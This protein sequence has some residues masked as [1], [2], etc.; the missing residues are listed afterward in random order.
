MI[1]AYNYMLEA[2]PLKRN[3]KYPV[4]RRNELRRVYNN[5]VDLSKSSP[6]YKINLSRENQ[7]YT[8]GIKEAALALKAVIKDMKDPEYSGFHSKTV[9]VSNESVLSAALLNEDTANLPDQ[10][11]FHIKS[12]ASIQMNKGRDLLQNSKGVP[13][14]EYLFKAQVGEEEY[15]LTFVQEDR[16]INRITLMNVAEFLNAS[17][18]GIHAVVENG[19]NKDYSRLMVL[20]EMSGRYGDRRFKFEDVDT[21][22]LG[23]VD[24]LGMNH[25]EKTASFAEFDINGINKQTATNTFTLENTLQITLNQTSDQPVTVRILPDSDRILTAVDSVLQSVNKLVKLAVDRTRESEDHYRAKKLTKELKSL[26]E[27]Y[28][29]ELAACGIVASED[30]SLRMEESL[31]VQAAQDG[32]MESLFTRENG[33]IARLLEKSESIAINPMDYLDKIVVTYPDSRNKQFRNPYVTSMYSGL[34][35]SSYC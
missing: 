21:Y 8:I 24:Y 6:L 12:L 3:A 15:R 28:Q 22:P 34:F 4:S 13:A 33:F 32:G 9:M 31:A 29:P 10:L 25:I 35:F 18:P 2:L 26:E 11:E 17:V 1:Q 16:T 5:I 30:G 20:S 27:L 7:E 23:L 14:G 19:E